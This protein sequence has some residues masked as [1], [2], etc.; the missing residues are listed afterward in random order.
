M[1]S[2]ALNWLERQAHNQLAQGASFGGPSQ[3]EILNLRV[4]N[5]VITRIKAF[6][7]F[8]YKVEI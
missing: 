8:G 2:T 5:F 6:I 3:N 1:P 4:S 7:Y